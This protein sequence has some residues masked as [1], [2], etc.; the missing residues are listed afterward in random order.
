VL[1]QVLLLATI[2]SQHLPMEVVVLTR[3]KFAMDRVHSVIASF[4]V[5]VYK[6]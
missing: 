6:G 1:A 5:E 2:V 3:L 4:N